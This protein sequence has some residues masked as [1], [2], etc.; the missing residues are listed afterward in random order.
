M[1]LCMVA[2]AS[3]LVGILGGRLN[4][5]W[6]S[7]CEREDKSRLNMPERPK[8]ILPTLQPRISI[9]MFLCLNW[10]DL[11]RQWDPRERGSKSTLKEAYKGLESSERCRYNKYAKNM[12]FTCTNNERRIYLIG[13]FLG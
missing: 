6:E 1:A 8:P 5:E 11:M 2:K 12:M 4:P 3:S 10:E 9:D 13:N 7:Y